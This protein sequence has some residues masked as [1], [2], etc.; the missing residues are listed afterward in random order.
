MTVYFTQGELGAGKGIYAA[1][2]AWRYYNNPDKNI[3]VATNYPLDTYRLNKDSDKDITVLPCSLRVED[4]KSLGDG[5]PPSYKDNFGCLI[6]DECSEFLNSRDFKRHDRLKMLDWFRH[7]RKHHWDVYFIVQH[8]D[9]LDSQLRDAVSE[10]LVMLRDLSKIRIPLYSTFKDMFPSKTPRRDKRRKSLFPH[11]VRAHI[12]Y[13]KKV[14]GEKPIDNYSIMAK[15][16]YDVYDTDFKFV[17]GTELLNNK[18]VDMRAPYTLLPGKYLSAPLSDWT[19]WHEGRDMA[20]QNITR[21][22][23]LSS[24]EMPDNVPPVTPEPPAS[25]PVKKSRFGFAF[26]LKTSLF[27]LL[28]YV[29]WQ[30]VSRYV[31]HSDAPVVQTVRTS[32]GQVAYMN[33]NGQAVVP[34]VVPAPPPEPVISSRWRLTGYL[35]LP[36]K[37]GYFILRDTTGNIRYFRSDKPYAGQFTQ[38]T[39][40]NEIVTFYSGSATAAPSSPAMPDLPGAVSGGMSAAVQGSVSSLLK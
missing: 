18:E 17:D 21:V 24:A 28:A 10:N 6:I 15:E 25:A 11:I 3:R 16:Y 19:N 31:F 23:Q 5:S 33:E 2:V 1:F 9:N 26:L 13:K 35:R 36:E 30:F 20:P 7:A 38:L 34:A 27:L 40:D 8:P 12:Y 4:L 32:S 29:V 39:V 14:A 37:A 22:T